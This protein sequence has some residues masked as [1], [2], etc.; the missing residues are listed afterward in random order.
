MDKITCSMDYYVSENIIQ[1]LLIIF[2]YDLP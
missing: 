2:E 1:K